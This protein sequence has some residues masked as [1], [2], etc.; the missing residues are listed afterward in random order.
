MEFEAD[1]THNFSDGNVAPRAGGGTVPPGTVA[2]PADP[3]SSVPPSP[4]APTGGGIPAPP[5]GFI[6]PSPSASP[7][8]PANNIPS[9]RAMLAKRSILSTLRAISRSEADAKSP[10]FQRIFCRGMESVQHYGGELHGVV[11]ALRVCFDA[12]EDMVHALAA[13]AAG[14]A[15]EVDPRQ[16]E[17]ASTVRKEEAAVA[18]RMDERD[19]GEDKMTT[20]GVGMDES[21]AA[22]KA[23]GWN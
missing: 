20:V 1:G 7:H 6:A 18:K 22:E 11:D 16:R 5:S 9:P 12:S 15:S 4:R 10:Y 23:M 8:S 2:P 21:L 17:A 14:V 19:N 13:A 3:L